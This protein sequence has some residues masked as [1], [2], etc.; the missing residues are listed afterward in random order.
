MLIRPVLPSPHRV[1][2]IA[3]LLIITWLFASVL[4]S[5]SENLSPYNPDSIVLPHDETCATHNWKPFRQQGMTPRKVYDLVMINT[6]L[7]WLEIRLNTT[8]DRV[9]YFV[10]VEGRKTFTGLDK[11]LTLKKNLAQFEQYKSKLIYHEIEYPPSFQAKRAWDRED[12]QRNAMFTQI[13]P[14]LNG[15]RAPNYGDVI[16]VSDADEIPRPETL[17]L[18]KSCRF[19]RRLTL[20]S[21][22]YYYSFQWRHQGGQD[23][24]HPQATF[25]QGPHRT[26][27]PNDLRNGLGFPPT[28][29]WDSAEKK[30]AAWHCSS[31][32]GTMREMLTK[33]E[34]VSHTYMNEKKYR[35]R[36]RIAERVRNGQD[37]WDRE[38]EVYYRV[39]NN[40]DVPGFLLYNQS[41]TRFPYLLSRDGVGAGFGDYDEDILPYK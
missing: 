37:L 25:Y 34:S 15:S 16:V 24:P 4:V 11:P 21:H 3:L 17:R 32:F 5:L 40:S 19:P 30:E 28:K 27:K 26:V 18:L 23:W 1:I 29:W 2:K 10:V 8:W 36:T 9:D 6:E 7:D 13:L 20:R 14:H 33:M 22:F 41:M 39:E 38:G 31:C 12:L 35:N